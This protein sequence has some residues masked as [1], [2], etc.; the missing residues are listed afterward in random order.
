[1]LGNGF[2]PYFLL[3]NCILGHVGILTTDETLD[4]LFIAEILLNLQEISNP[5]KT[6]FMFID[7]KIM[8]LNLFET[9]GQ[10]GCRTTLTVNVE[11]VG[12]CLHGNIVWKM[13]GSKRW[14]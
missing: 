6:N 14:V 5:F 1:M 7:I 10:V 2:Q 11:N 9:F 8:E 4:L 13:V 3:M 12:T